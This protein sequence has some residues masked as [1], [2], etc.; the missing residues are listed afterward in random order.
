MRSHCRAGPAAYVTVSDV[1][2]WY[3]PHKCAVAASFV[4]ELT[5]RYVG[6]MHP[7]DASMLKP[8]GQ[9]HAVAFATGT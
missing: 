2:N 8:V 4:G 5:L 6:G 3:V 7:P 9:A 1:A